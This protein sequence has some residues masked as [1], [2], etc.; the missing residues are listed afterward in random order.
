MKK[1]IVAVILVVVFIS[2]AGCGVKQTGTT[3]SNPVPQEQT[4][5][6]H[7]DSDPE[8]ATVFVDD[9]YVVRTPAL[10]KLTIGKHNIL[11]KKGGYLNYT[12][13]DAEVREDTT[14][15]KAVL[16]KSDDESII[17]FTE[18]TLSK[19]LL[20]ATAKLVF[21]SDGSL[22][23]SDENGHDIEKVADIGSNY[24]ARIYGV[25]P[26]SKWTILNLAPKDDT[27]QFLYA[28][29]VED[30][31]L[32]KIAEDTWEGGFHISF[33]LGNDKLLYWFQGPNAPLCKL[34]CFDMNTKSVTYLL[35][36]S[37][38][39]KEKAF[40]F[41]ISPDGKYLAY[42]GG[43][44]DIFPDNR[45]AVY[46]KNLETGRLKMLLKGSDTNPNFGEDYFT[47]VKFVNGG[48]EILCSKETWDHSSTRNPTIKYFIVDFDGYSKEISSEEESKFVMQDSLILQEKLAKF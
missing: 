2:F 20:G 45:T 1:V 41:D 16:R 8:G 14:E 31:Y 44:V 17:K 24:Q 42:A 46:L 5:L 9:N 37:N 13:E 22:Y 43:N 23:I 12:V 33:E 30:L 19:T 36:C 38:N 27:I 18:S 11:F 25:S 3:A 40:A 47:D 21:V 32:I 39:K 48:K 26:N 29:N 10:I 15:I 6:V 35:D 7:I 4:K 28:L 34:A